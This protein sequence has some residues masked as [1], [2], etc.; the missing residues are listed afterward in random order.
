M[1]D[2]PYL[3]EEAAT[4][5]EIDRVAGGGSEVTEFGA[6]VEGGVTVEDTGAGDALASYDIEGHV[7]VHRADDVRG[8]RGDEVA[9]LGR[10]CLNVEGSDGVDG[11]LRT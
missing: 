10:S 7:A 1:G 4:V 3:D 2:S 8:A 11:D 5:I 9:A 6:L